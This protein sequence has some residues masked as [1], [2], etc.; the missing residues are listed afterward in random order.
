LKVSLTHRAD[1]RRL[2]FITGHDRDGGLPADM[3]WSTIADPG[4]TTIVYM[5]RKT[6]RELSA[7]AIA[8]GLDPSTP[9]VAVTNATRPNEAV[10]QATIADVC[11]KSE[12]DSHGGPMLVLIGN[13]MAQMQYRLP[14]RGDTKGSD[15]AAAL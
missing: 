1:A 3:D 5:P 7:R 8:E 2:Q 12:A 4:T 15:L 10:V 11:D 9:A 13:A 6:L 14:V